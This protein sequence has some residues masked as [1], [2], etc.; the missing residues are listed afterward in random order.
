M[1][2]DIPA[3]VVDICVIVDAIWFV[4]VVVH[5]SVTMIAVPSGTIIGVIV[6][7]AI[8]VAPAALVE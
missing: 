8:V 3:G 1:T 7:V 4:D 6:I 2:D 5:C